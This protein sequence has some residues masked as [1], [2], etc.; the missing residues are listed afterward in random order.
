MATSTL[1]KRLETVENELFQIKQQLAERQLET[2]A[3]NWEKIFGTF[4]ESEGFEEA[5][6]LGR[7]YRDAQNMN[8][9]EVITQ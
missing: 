4:A 3:A 6:R 2:P 9:D 7:E 5:M 8:D 1:E